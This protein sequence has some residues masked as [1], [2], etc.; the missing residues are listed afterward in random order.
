VGRQE[1]SCFEKTIAHV[2][3]EEAGC[4]Q[5]DKRNPG[6]LL[7]HLNSGAL[8]GGYYGSNS[9]AGS[10]PNDGDL[11]LEAVYSVDEEGHFGQPIVNTRGVLLR[12]EQDSYIE[13][14]SIPEE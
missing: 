7:V 12:K 2:C 4:C 8:L 1:S 5:Y 13:L 9:N 14:F 6:F 3:S 10:Y 11:Y